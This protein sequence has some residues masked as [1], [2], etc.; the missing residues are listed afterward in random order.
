MPPG[1]ADGG[2]RA[3][4]AEGESRGPRDA[5]ARRSS[6]GRTAAAARLWWTRGGRAGVRARPVWGAPRSTTTRPAV[7]KAWKAQQL[8]RVDRPVHI[9]HRST[10]GVLLAGMVA[11]GGLLAA[12]PGGVAAAGPFRPAG[13]ARPIHT[14]GRNRRSARTPRRFPCPHLVT[15]GGVTRVAGSG[16]PTLPWAAARGIVLHTTTSHC[17]PIC[18]RGDRPR[19]IGVSLSSTRS[20]G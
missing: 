7:G 16:R 4:S 12:E 20:T 8:R 19:S 3:L 14:Q 1:T 13:G 9:P 10:R 11:A 18:T 2:V 17:V 6:A 15:I 5:P